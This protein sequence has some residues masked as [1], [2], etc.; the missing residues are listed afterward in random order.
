MSI[1]AA[2]IGA[3]PILIEDGLQIIAQIVQ[4]IQQAQASGSKTI[5][6]SVLLADVTARN[7]AQA[8]LDK[9]IA[10]D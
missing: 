5:D 4:A 8:Q 2:L 1:P 10:S 9:D 6:P 3:S 7:S